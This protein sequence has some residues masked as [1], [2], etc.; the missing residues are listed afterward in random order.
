MTDDDSGRLD[1]VEAREVWKRAARLQSETSHEAEAGRSEELAMGPPEGLEVRHVRDAAVEAGIEARFVDAALADVMAERSLPVVTKDRTMAARFF[2][3]LLDNVETRRTIKAPPSEALS[4]IIEV[5]PR[6]PY[7]LALSDRVG[8]PLD[9]GTLVFDIQGIGALQKP[10]LA[11][12][13]SMSAVR[14]VYVS[15]RGIEGATPTC[16]VTLRGPIAWSHNTGLAHGL[17]ASAVGGGAGGAAFGAGAAALVGGLIASPLGIAAVAVSSALGLVTGASAGRK[18]YRVYCAYGIE[19]ARRALEKVL[20]AVA[21][22][23]EQSWR[24]ASKGE[25]S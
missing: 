11:K 9:S 3:G 1:D 19:R 13:V 20:L 16:E 17:A 24:K 8:D 15:L 23:A 21:V 6:D 18:G 5:F 10:W 22:Q 4:T 7:R 2:G 14:Q 25:A 12:E